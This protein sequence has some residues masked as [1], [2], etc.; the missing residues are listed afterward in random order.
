MFTSYAKHNKITD[1]RKIKHNALIDLTNIY[2]THNPLGASV[3]LS[4][5]SF[6]LLLK[7]DFENMDNMAFYA[8]DKK[9]KKQC[10]GKCNGKCD[11]KCKCNN[12]DDDKSQ[13]EDSDSDDDQDQQ[14]QINQVQH[15]LN[16]H[17]SA[18]MY[19]GAVSVVGLYVLFKLMKLKK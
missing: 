19:L 6:D 18:Q 14:S 12:G 3:N 9:D 11:G 7:K 8:V 13:D 2:K 4:E 16:T 15:F 1:D 10:N 17:T 5:P